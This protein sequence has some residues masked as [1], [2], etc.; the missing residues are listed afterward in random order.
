MVDVNVSDL[1]EFEKQ[2]ASN[3]EFEVLDITDNQNNKQEKQMITVKK[4]VIL[5]YISDSTGCGFI[6]CFQPFSYMNFVF[7]KNS[8]VV[9][10]ISPLFLYQEDVLIRARAIYFQRQMS[11]DHLVHIRNYKELQKT[12]KYKMVYE[13]DDM[14]WFEPDGVTHGVPEYN[15]GRKNITKEIQE[16]SVE[17]MK[18]MDQII[19]TTDYLANYIKN[20]L[21][22][23]VPVKVIPNQVAKYFWGNYRKP[24][25]KTR[26]EKPKVIYTGSPTH[27]MNPVPQIGVKSHPGDWSNPAWIEWVTKSVMDGKIEFVCLGGLPFF[28][29]PIKD[30][31]K[32]HNWVN[33]WQYHQVILS[34]RADIGLMPLVPNNFNR[35]KSD[36]K[37]LEYAAAGILG[38][39]TTFSDGTPSPYDKM[40]VTLPDNCSYSDIEDTVNRILEPDTY[41]KIIREQY[42]FLDTNGR[43][44]ESKEFVDNFTSVF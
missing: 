43:W 7:G 28:F 9:P 22:I 12:Y 40:P 24:A 19:V 21:K 33:S 25:I 16:S 4:N 15:F 23:N 36:L 13:I 38:I 11:P 20:D 1:K 34:H 35:S 31:I 41:N 17:I 37:Y 8:S 2:M 30:R 3:N 39:G 32:I 27:Y 44:L 6:R 26:I 29:E 18:M 10:M 42:K 14:I 5:A